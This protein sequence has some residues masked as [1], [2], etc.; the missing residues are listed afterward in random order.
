MRHPPFGRAS[1]S[2]YRACS[3][4]PVELGVGDLGVARLYNPGKLIVHVQF[5]M[6]NAMKT[7]FDVKCQ[8]LSDFFRKPD[9][10]LAR[11]S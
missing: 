6:K 5:H 10:S 2:S 7:P 4:P 1:I 3:K 9:C 8:K 11:S